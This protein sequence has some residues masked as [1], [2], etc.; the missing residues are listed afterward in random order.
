[1]ARTLV[2]DGEE[3]V[4]PAGGWARFRPDGA[5]ERGRVRYPFPF[6]Q[7]ARSPSGR[8]TAIL[9]RRGTK[10]LLLDGQS[11]LRELDRSYYLADAYEY[12]IALGRLPDGREIVVHCPNRYDALQIDLLETGERL[13]QRAANPTDFF[14]SRLQVSADGRYLLSAGWIWHP[15]EGLQVFDLQRGLAEPTS[16]DHDPLFGFGYA[17]FDIEAAAFSFGG[18][19]VLATSDAVDVLDDDYGE[20]AGGI[21]PREVVRYS[22]TERR[23][24]SRA[25]VSEPVGTIMPVGPEGELAVGFFEHPKLFDTRSGEVIAR[26]P[27]LSMGRQAGSIIRGIELPLPL[28]LDPIRRR[29]AVGG[30]SGVTAILLG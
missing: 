1:M 24:L 19:V 25:R 4:D 27:D 28:A 20:F 13:T 29:F 17:G 6:D 2:W 3:L 10:A 23:I 22:P 26:W 12:P 21:G 8:Y 9:V 30:S 18:V 14:H 11:V 7:A 15:V 5:W 16:L